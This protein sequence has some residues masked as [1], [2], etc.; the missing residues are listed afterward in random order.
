M[1]KSVN[2]TDETKELIR[3]VR[4]LKFSETTGRITDSYIINQA[5]LSI[6]SNTLKE[7]TSLLKAKK[8]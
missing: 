3:E 1:R 6:D 7:E 8:N 2:V 4:T 5:I